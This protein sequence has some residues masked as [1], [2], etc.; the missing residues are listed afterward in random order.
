MKNNLRP[1][2]NSIRFDDGEPV[3]RTHNNG[4]VEVMRTIRFQVCHKIGSQI[5]CLYREVPEGYKTDGATIPFFARCFLPKNLANNAGVVHDYLYQT[6]AERDTMILKF[7]LAPAEVDRRWVADRIFLG[8]LRKVDLTKKR[9]YK[10]NIAAL[11]YNPVG[12]VRNC[13][14]HWIGVPLGYMAIRLFGGIFYKKQS[15]E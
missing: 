11:V 1:K 3:L 2:I 5:T 15:G 6:P 13:I 14:F 7:D 12:V 9:E 10:T 4:V 8:L